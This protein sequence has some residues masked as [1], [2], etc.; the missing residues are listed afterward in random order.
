MPAHRHDAGTGSLQ[1]NTSAANT[2]DPRGNS[3][4]AANVFN[5]VAADVDLQVSFVDGIGD[6]GG[7]QA[8]ENMPPYLTLS[9]IIALQGLFPSRS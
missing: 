3:L 6:T 2:A 4:A 8:H 7:G 1:V 9:F 5:S